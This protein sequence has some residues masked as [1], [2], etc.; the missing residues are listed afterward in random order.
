MIVVHDTE[1]GIN[2]DFSEISLRITLPERKNIFQ[3]GSC[4]V[5]IPRNR[6]RTWAY[7]IYIYEG[8]CLVF[9]TDTKKLI[10]ILLWILYRG[11]LR[12]LHMINFDASV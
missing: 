5:V 10:A 3:H 11:L 1:R 4:R 12:V 9:D 2:T 6:R 8:I 7:A